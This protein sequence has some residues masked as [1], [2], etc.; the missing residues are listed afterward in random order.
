[1]LGFFITN[2][3]RLPMENISNINW[4]ELMGKEARGINDD[5]LGEVQSVE[6]G[7]VV[8]QAGIVDKITYHLPKNLVER[9]DGHNLLFRI[10]K[11][12]AKSKYD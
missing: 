11:E 4:N 10:T 12:E 7:Y 8:T 6:E 2:Q 3:R 5:D 1:M 9:Y